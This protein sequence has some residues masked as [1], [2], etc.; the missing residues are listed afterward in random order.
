M[1][2]RGGDRQTKIISSQ[3]NIVKYF[4]KMES[5][6]PC[7]WIW[8]MIFIL[9]FLY[10]LIYIIYILVWKLIHIFS[11]ILKNTV[12]KQRQSKTNI[13]HPQNFEPL[14]HCMLFPSTLLCKWYQKLF[15]SC[16]NNSSRTT[17]W[18][19]HTTNYSSVSYMKFL[20]SIPRRMLF[21][22]NY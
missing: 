3:S 14:L 13:P 19:G 18:C 9:T 15:S 22:Y 11:I 5:S 6:M 10:I 20:H 8:M 17:V 21:I 2:E 7:I 1:W 16:V 4:I 12:K